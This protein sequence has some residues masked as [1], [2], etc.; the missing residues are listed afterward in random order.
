MVVAHALLSREMRL[1]PDGVGEDVEGA[2][3]S[4]LL[5]HLTDGLRAE[6]VVPVM[7]RDGVSMA[8]LQAMFALPVFSE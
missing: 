4:K 3:K 2:V 7:L 5:R 6:A 1:L 8:S